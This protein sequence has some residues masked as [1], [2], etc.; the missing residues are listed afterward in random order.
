MRN[1]TLMTVTAAFFL[2]SIGLAPVVAY[3]QPTPSQMKRDGEIKDPVAADTAVAKDEAKAA[4]KKAHKAHKSAK[5]AASK[6]KV[7]AQ[8]SDEAIKDTTADAAEAAK[9]KAEDENH[10]TV[11]IVE[12][13]YTQPLNKL[14]IV[15]SDGGVWEQDDTIRLTFTPRAGQSVEINKTRFGGYFCKFDRTNAVRCVRKN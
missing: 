13:A 5:K 7:A 2:S 14:L 15:T 9:A 12:V 3:A 4:H 10:I 8:K 6:A 1:K 11:Q